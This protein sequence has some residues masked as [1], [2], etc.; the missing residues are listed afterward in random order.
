MTEKVLILGAGYA[1]TVVANKLAR[2]FR[3]EI[4]RGDLNVTILDKDD[5]NINQGGFTFLPFGLYSPE[6]LKRPRKE[7]ISPRINCVFGENGEIT[8]ADLENRKV[9]VKSGD[10]FSYDYLVIATGS[11]TDISNIPGLSEDYNTF[12]TSMDDAFKLKEKIENFEQ[13]RIAISVAQMPVSCPGATVKFAVM[14]NDY[15]K[16]MKTEEMCKNIQISFFWPM[17]PIGP[18]EFNKVATK[19]F[20]DDNI[21]INRNFK[22]AEVDS[23]NKEIVSQN[24]DR[25]KYD[26]LITT[27]PHKSPQPII[28]SGLTDETGW[29]PVDK[30][31]L[32]YRGPAGNHDEV[33]V[34]GDSGPSSV[35]KSGIGAH[36]Q[37]LVVSHN[38][39]NDIHGHGTKVSYMGE[40]G[41]PYIGAMPTPFTKGQAYIPSWSYGAP[42]ESFEP[43]RLGWYIYRMYYYIH[44]D[45]GLKALF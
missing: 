44:W 12:Y 39:I 4:A 24:G 21:E 11:T 34:A 28:D 13:G 22:L 35:I 8:G 3:R 33:Y 31:T 43:T 20:E 29:I 10:T 30:F 14:L 27:P 42:P 17:E 1:G 18:P 16:F 7:V 41:C 45:A 15:I 9:Q 23:K 5:M 26:L 32:Q 37:S 40:V 38:L 25:E 6:D 19:V 36:Y 2:E